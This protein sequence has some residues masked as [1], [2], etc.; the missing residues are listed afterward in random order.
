MKNGIIF[1]LFVCS[2]LLFGQWTGSGTAID[3]FQISTVSDLATL[4]SNVNA[5]NAYS[6][7]HFKQMNDID[8]NVNPHNTGSGW[9]PIG[10]M[11]TVYFSGTYHGDNRTISNL[12]INRPSTSWIGLFACI[13]GAVSDLNFTNVNV[14]GKDEVGALAGYSGAVVTNCTA[15]GSVAGKYTE[16]VGGGG[17]I[18]VLLGWNTGTVTGCHTS[19]TAAGENNY[20]GGLVGYNSNGGDIVDCYSSAVITGYDVCGGL[21]G[22]HKDNGS[23]ISGSYAT[24][25]VTSPQNYI[26]G[27]VGGCS[28]AVSN[29]YAT[30]AVQGVE[31]VGG[32]IGQ[33]SGSV[34]DSYATGS[35]T[36]NIFGAGDW[37]VGGLV[38]NMHYGGSVARCYATGNVTSSNYAGGLVGFIAYDGA[39]SFVSNSYST[40]S[41]SGYNAGSSIGYLGWGTVTNCY[42]IGIVSG[43]NLGGFAGVLESATWGITTGCFWNTTTTGQTNG[44]SGGSMTGLT[45][46]NTSEM[47]T[48]STFYGAG[49]SVSVWNMGDGLNNGYAY[50]DWQNPSGTELPVELTSF[51]VTSKNGA[52]LLNWTTASEV[53]NYGFE[54]EKLSNSKIIKFKNSAWEKIGFVEGNGTSNTPKE[55]SFVDR[56]VNTDQYQYRLKQIDR[57]GTFRYSH[58]VEVS[59]AGAPQ[60]FTLEQNYPNPFNPTTALSYQLSENG[61][62]TLIIYDALGREAATLVNEVKA[63]G[64]YSVQFDGTHLTSGIYFAQLV[65]GGKMQMRKLLL[66][67]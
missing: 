24:G 14:T 5:G 17:S 15:S 45:G 65:S 57:D 47:K 4:A 18:G 39:E 63:P 21:V 54:I 33:L 23:T 55:Y 37:G 32:L 20:T 52:A 60:Q 10:I 9:T 1:F 28:A 46:K 64:L 16:G 38:G 7:I 53:S 59:V 58:A 27:L 12:F 66:M 25:T 48:S 2:Q 3:P 31:H 43:T 36:A 44:I 50:L 19:G 13:N 56:S 40:G 34:T 30:G 29:C 41:A 11:Y 6:G 51:T 49:W 22:I 35:A 62:T 8:M 26:G 42:A 61:M 67:K